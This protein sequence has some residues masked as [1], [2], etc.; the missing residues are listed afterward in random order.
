MIDKVSLKI[1]LDELNEA[2]LVK[3]KVP[4]VIVLIRM[5]DKKKCVKK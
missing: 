1:K 5:I 3:G 4:V 2:K